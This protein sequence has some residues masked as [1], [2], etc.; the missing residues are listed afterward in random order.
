MRLADAIRGLYAVV[1][2]PRACGALLD[3]GAGVIQL[4]A[5]T[6]STRVLIDAGR[7]LREATRGRV[8]FI[9]NDRCDVALWCDADGVHLGQDDLPIAEARKLMGARWIG[10][11]T[12]DFGQARAAVEAGADYI[13]FGPVFPTATKER[14]DPVT[15]LEAL[16]RV[17]AAVPVPV[18]AIGGI[19]PGNVA[20]VVACGAAAAVSISALLGA[21]DVRQAAAAMAAAFRTAAPPT[22]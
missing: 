15:G 21:K 13:G 18:V 5:K 1:E 11:S 14:P 7:A 4:R 3:G 8:P 20:S 10:C 6:A 9:V 12:H 19:G 16:R 22:T 2:D 17:C